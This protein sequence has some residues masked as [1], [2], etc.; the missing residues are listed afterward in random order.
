[1]S[2]KSL[3]RQSLVSSATPAGTGPIRNA[4][5]SDEFWVQMLRASFIAEC[6]RHRGRSRTDLRSMEVEAADR[7]VLL[8]ALK[9]SYSRRKDTLVWGRD[10][11]CCK[12]K[13]VALSSGPTLG[14]L[15]A[16]AIS[17]IWTV[18]H[19]VRHL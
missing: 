5:E 9:T 12:R 19:V 11:L 6:K 14:L 8:R 4:L 18:V 2:S 1:M 13:H 10:R 17:A 3:N 15:S 7:K 16:I